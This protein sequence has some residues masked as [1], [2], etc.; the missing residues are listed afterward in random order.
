MTTVNIPIPFDTLIQA[1]KSLSLAEQ[2]KLL[3][4][5][6]NQIST[7]ED[8]WENSPEIMAEVNCAKEAYQGGDYL[9]L[10]EFI[11]NS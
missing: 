7:A 4:L 9:T 10:E 3:E 6:E 11:A 8:K 5:L 2:E 1:I